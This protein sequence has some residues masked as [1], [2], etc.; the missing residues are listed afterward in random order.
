MLSAAFGFCMVMPFAGGF[1]YP[2]IGQEDLLR[3]LK[4]GYR[5][6]QPDNCSQE[7]LVLIVVQILWQ[8]L[9]ISFCYIK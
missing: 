8:V 7:V 2:T 3:L 1:P 4:A 9:K 6:E 5:M